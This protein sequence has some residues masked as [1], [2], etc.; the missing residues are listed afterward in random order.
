[1]SMLHLLTEV[2]ALEYRHVCFSLFRGEPVYILT[3]I[4]N[5]A[6]LLQF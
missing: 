5:S 1:M 3:K 6:S 2:I 4:T